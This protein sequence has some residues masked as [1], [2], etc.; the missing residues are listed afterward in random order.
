MVNMPQVPWKEGVAVLLLAFGFYYLTT[1]INYVENELQSLRKVI[2]RM[3]NK[4]SELDRNNGVTVG[5]VLL[6]FAQT[7]S[8][9]VLPKLL[10]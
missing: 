3:A 9:F 8:S 6:Y 2:Q 7:L 1:R 10:D 4:L 5:D